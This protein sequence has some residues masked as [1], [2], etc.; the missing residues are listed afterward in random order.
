[1]GRRSF[2]TRYF[3]PAPSRPELPRWLR[4][5]LPEGFSSRLLAAAIVV[6]IMVGLLVAI[7]DFIV[8]ELVLEPVL[9]MPLWIQI[10]APLF[11]LLLTRLILLR[12][13]GGCSP[14]TSEEYISEFHNRHPA[15]ELKPLR[16]RLLGGIATIG[17]G[18]SVGL[19]GPSIYL[20]S[21]V[22]LRVQRVAERYLG[23]GTAK[24][25]LTAGAAAGVSALFQAPA[26]GLIFALES[27]YRDWA[28][29]LNLV[30]GLC[31][32]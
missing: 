18:G 28:D 10:L 1:M 30:Q 11:G 27:P 12:L 29:P 5:I 8:L 23:W 31:V 32:F 20:G 19:E 4:G 3:G 16:A 6:G 7:L 14:S 17:T 21:A 22:G 25:L 26:T 15:M 9:H 24:L 2:A 13:G